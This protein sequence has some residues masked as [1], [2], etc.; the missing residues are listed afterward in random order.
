M[1]NICNF[2]LEKATPVKEA[3]GVLYEYRHSATGARL[4]FLKTENQNK[5]FSVTFKTIPEDHT[6]VFHILEHSVFC[7]SEKYP[8][9]DPFLEM[10]KGSVNTFLNAMTFPDRTVF[11]VS[12]RNE[13]DFRNLVSIYLDAVFRPCIYKNEAVFMQEGWHYE[14]GEESISLNGV[15]FNE[16][17][18]VEAS[19]DSRMQQTMMELLFPDTCYRFLAGGKPAD[20]PKLS[21]EAYLSA[22]KKYYRPGNAVFYLEGALEL[23]EIVSMIEEYL[24]SASTSETEDFEAALQ[25]K[26]A[27]RTLKLTYP[28]MEDGPI[29]E[30]W[31]YEFGKILDDPDASEEEQLI[32]VS[33]GKILTDYLTGSMEAPLQQGIL[34]NQ[35]GQGVEMTVDTSLR[36]SY[37]SLKVRNSTAE[38]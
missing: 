2:Q 6:G 30:Q 29:E 7:G 18:G 20:I 25:P 10:E 3:D 8:V 38:T 21:Y 23:P 14:F 31:F 17:K 9:K 12:S 37:L 1:Q 4:L 35:L 33:A 16:M 27:P 26:I 19:V 11:P 15:V 36:Q 5:L 32:K 13:K 28:V 22:H 24:A 34:M